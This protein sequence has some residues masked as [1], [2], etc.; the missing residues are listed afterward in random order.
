MSLIDQLNLELSDRKCEV[1]WLADNA[2]QKWNFNTPTY[3]EDD[4]GYLLG[5][6]SAREIIDHIFSFEHWVPKT[7]F[8]LMMH[9]LAPE[10]Y[11]KRK[12][13]NKDVYVLYYNY[14]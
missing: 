9:K 10:C 7:K 5:E 13:D 8:T 3:F 4:K 12:P 14:E 2:D 11:E 6:K 1:A